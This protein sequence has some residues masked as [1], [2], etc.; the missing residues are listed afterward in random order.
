MHH[1]SITLSKNERLVNLDAA[2]SLLQLPSKSPTEADADAAVVV[3]LLVVIA[4]PLS[5]S[6]ALC[7]Y[8]QTLWRRSK[9][10]F[11]PPPSWSQLLFPSTSPLLFD[12]IESFFKKR[13]WALLQLWGSCQ[14]CQEG[15]GLKELSVIFVYTALASSEAKAKKAGL[16]HL[17][18]NL[19]WRETAKVNKKLLKPWWCRSK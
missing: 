1:H 5:L 9:G 19:V 3:P 7:M 2:F 14:G 10:S 11:W 13:T 6:L 4:F 15:H 18:N 12:L 16:S 17:E 8:A